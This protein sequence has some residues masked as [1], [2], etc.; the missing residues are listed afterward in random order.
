[1]KTFQ[2]NAEPRTDLGKKAAKALRASQKIPCVLNGGKV[3]ELKDGKYEGTLAEGEK[4]VEIGRDGKA[5]LTTDFTVN[6]NDVRKLIY[7]PDVYVVELNINGVEKKAVLKDIQWHPINDSILH[8]DFLEVNEDKPVVVPIPVKVE[9]HAAGVKAGGKLFLSMKK[10]KVRG[11]Y[12]DIPERIVV[13]V[14]NVAIGHAIKVGDLKFDKFELANA[15]DLVI[16]GVRATRAAAAAAAETE[17][18]EE[19][20][21]PAAE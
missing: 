15:K 21:A 13:N 11:I 16:T 7:T 3:V 1:M 4:V 12:T 10:V 2:L 8:L 17:E 5:V 14:D 18:G 19:G 6:F 20:E 9:G